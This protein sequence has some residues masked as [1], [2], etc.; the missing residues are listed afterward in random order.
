MEESWRRKWKVVRKWNVIVWKGI[1][2]SASW[3]H[4]T[5]LQTH[6]ASV[7]LKSCPVWS[8]L[9]TFLLRILPTLILVAYRSTMLTAR[10]FVTRDTVRHPRSFVFGKF[11]RK[12]KCSWSEAFAK[13]GLIV[14]L[15]SRVTWQF[16][17]VQRTPELDIPQLY[18]PSTVRNWPHSF[19]GGYVPILL[20]KLHKWR[21]HRLWHR[22]VTMTLLEFICFQLIQGKSNET[23]TWCNIVQV[24]FLQGHSTCFGRQAPIIR[25][26]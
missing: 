6:W 10:V 19:T 22:I 12:P 16:S 18:D 5:L 14:C 17:E 1:L 7:S 8:V 21:R 13:R 11:V 25:S 20:K 2:F 26:I 24:L 15:N 9:S 4:S 23:P 3:H